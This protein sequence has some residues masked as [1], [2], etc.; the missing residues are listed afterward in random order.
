MFL[1]NLVTMNNQQRMKCYLIPYFSSSR[2]EVFNNAYNFCIS[3]LFGCIYDHLQANNI[4]FQ[5]VEA[6]PNLWFVSVRRTSLECI[7]HLL[8]D[9]M[10]NQPRVGRGRTAHISLP[11]IYRSNLQSTDRDMG[12]DFEM[13]KYIVIRGDSFLY[14]RFSLVFIHVYIYNLHI[15]IYLQMITDFVLP[16]R[17]SPLTLLNLVGGEENPP[18]LNMKRV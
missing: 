17:F 9:S 2:M 11:K 4:N 6:I 7:F 18:N 10:G 16:R 15:Y 8:Q 14:Y 1:G 3:I 13:V 12:Y 5:G